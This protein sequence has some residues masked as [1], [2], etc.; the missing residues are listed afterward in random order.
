MST[1]TASLP[2][3]FELDDSRLAH[4]PPEARGLAR[5]HV[6]LMV[7]DGSR[8][9]MHRRFDALA[10]SLQ[11][12]D[13]LVVNISATVAAALD[14]W[15]DGHPVVV[16]L[17]TELPGGAWLVEVRQPHDGSTAP[18]QVTQPGVVHL[19]GG[20]EVRLLTPFADSQRLWLAALSFAPEVQPYLAQHGRPIRYRYVP[21]DWPLSAYQSVFSRLPGSAEMP[22]ASRPFTTEVVAD[23]V[24]HGIT[25]APLVLHTG[26]SSLEGHE[27]PYPER[28][29][30][31]RPTA[32]L[33]NSTHA[34]GGRV[35]AVGTTVVRA[36]ETVADDHGVAHPGRGWTDVV[37][38]PE[39]PARAVDGLITGW[40]EP[41]ASHLLMLEA[42]AGREA[43]S[44]AYRAA[45]AGGYLW[46]EF[47][48]SHLLIA[49]RPRR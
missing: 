10:D 39:R 19:L 49:D 12:G 35:I 26:V 15:W 37:V 28:Y 38:S 18:L 25:V 36:L 23:L 33:V 3:G 21:V 48:D 47:G 20:G 41:E 42:I 4:E 32:A 16:H 17:S 43:V 14:G 5:D 45:F 13:L 11:A 46:H 34:E 44:V 7:S 29:D 2:L 22:S 6:R 40:H 9:P 30:V 27:A 31:S 1:L 8:A 24:R